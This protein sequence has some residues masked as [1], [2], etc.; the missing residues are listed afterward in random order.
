MKTT[1]FVACV[2]L[3]LFCHPQS[4]GALVLSG[5]SYVQTFDSIGSGLPT[6]WSVRTGANAS[7]EGTAA[8]FTTAATSWG[9]T[10]GAF[11]NVASS[12]GLTSG[13]STAVQAASTDR[14]LGIRQTGTLG[15]PGGAFV[16]QIDKTLGLKNFALSLKAQ[17]LSVQT[18][19]TTWTIDYRIGDSGSFTTL[20]TYSDPG[21]FGSTSFSFNSSQ[22]ST[23]NNQA[24][25]IWFRVVALGGSTGSSSRDTFAIDDFT[26]GYSPVPE[27]HVLGIISGLGLLA[28]FGIRTWRERRSGGIGI[29]N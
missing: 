27:P 28:I 7:F 3:F 11:K 15:D 4:Q 20:A 19:S 24:S 6:G 13:A 9:D 25:D 2:G 16:L 1:Y 17:M 5:T 12:D 10:T 21:A 22:L 29:G 26:L 23:W 8:S 18:R 14:A